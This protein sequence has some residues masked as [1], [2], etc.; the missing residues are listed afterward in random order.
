MGL[1]EIVCDYKYITSVLSWFIFSIYLSP[2]FTFIYIK[3][4]V[5]MGLIGYLCYLKTKSFCLII[6]KEVF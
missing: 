4:K 1:G 2:L 3:M 5:A 6:E